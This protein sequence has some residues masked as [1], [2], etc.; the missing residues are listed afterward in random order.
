[1]TFILPDEKSLIFY[2]FAKSCAMFRCSKIAVLK[3]ILLLLILSS[4]SSCAFFRPR[5]DFLPN[6]VP[7]AP[8]Y[9]NLE[10]WA[11]HPAKKDAADRTPAQEL[12]DR[13]NTAQVDVF[14]LH[15]TTFTHKAGKHEWNAALD[16][17]KLN[18]KTDRTTILYQASIFNGAGRVFA[19]RYRQAHLKSF[20]TKKHRD[21]GH[22]A[23]ELAYED[24]QAAFEHYLK[25]DN[26][27]RPLIIASHSQGSWHGMKLIKAYFDGKPLQKQ[28]VA[29]YLVGF[30]ITTNYFDQ[31]S[32]CTTAVQTGCF[33][34]WRTFK[35]GYYPHFYV[36]DAGI[37]AVN[38]LT[39]SVDGT[40]A[41]NTT[42]EGAVLRNFGIYPQITDA[43]VVDGM[44]WCKKPKFPGS[45]LMQ[46]RNYHP[47][48][49]NLYYLNVRNNAIL[50][51][52]EFL[53]QAGSQ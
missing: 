8:D 51:S 2:T 20:F 42:N 33:C 28:L 24:V 29:A 4:L 45:F 26:Q 25:H 50:R 7:T 44:L 14:F 27:G 43:Q 11:A 23:L 21:A 38:P 34:S 32:V 41:P 1:M 35:T 49:F 18:K 37:V 15:P 17:Q 36:K 3:G 30:P 16:N 31:I 13:Q 6:E 9:N 39:W 52:E 47:G 5:A 40:Y 53:R 46:T 22:Q 19:P 12:V 48:D 10:S